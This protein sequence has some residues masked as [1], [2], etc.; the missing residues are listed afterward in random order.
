MKLVAR[1]HEDECS[2]SSS[3]VLQDP[4]EYRFRSY[5][6]KFTENAVVGQVSENVF[7]NMCRAALHDRIDFTTRV[8]R[9]G[10]WALLAWEIASG[11]GRVRGRAPYS[12]PRDWDRFKHDPNNYGGG[13]PSPQQT[14]YKWREVDNLVFRYVV[15]DNLQ[16]TELDL[17]QEHNGRKDVT[18]TK[19][20][21]TG[22]FRY[23]PVPLRKQR[24]EA[25]AL[26]N[27]YV[28]GGEAIG[29]SELM[30]TSK[31]YTQ[32]KALRTVGETW[33]DIAPLFSTTWTELRKSYTSAES[34]ENQH[35]T[36]GMGEA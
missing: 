16:N 26:L 27:V 5:S 18:M 11:K 6:H 4:K 17:M 2:F 19:F 21:E 22:D 33:K 9:N 25:L 24:D 20:L 30:L 1:E 34:R 14:E 28:N 23:L 3:A 7:Y 29:T 13:T 36:N 15:V 12:G 10:E 35:G 8:N 32:V 31:Q